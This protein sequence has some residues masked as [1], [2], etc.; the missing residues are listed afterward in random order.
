MAGKDD[1]SDED[2]RL[3]REAVGNVKPVLTDRVTPPSR[4]PL[5]R[6]KLQ[7][8]VHERAQ[9]PPQP[10]SDSF[11]TA[12]AEDP[13]TADDLLF[14]ARPGLQRKAIRRLKRGQLRCEA[15]LDM[16]G[17]T[18]DEARD[19]LAEFIDDCRRRHLRSVI[20]I[21]GKGFRSSASRP[22]LKSMVNNW[23]RQ[24][25]AVIAFCSAQPADGGSGAVYVLLK[26]I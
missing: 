1:L 15:T 13:V 4:P 23:L 9:P 22:I 20:I 10:F 26:M 12:A 19:C 5:P 25:D 2:R 6:K 8:K 3:F 11:F 17:M 21:H 14:Y 16:H 7:Q 18:V 24:H